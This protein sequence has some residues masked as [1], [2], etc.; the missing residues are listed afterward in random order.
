[1]G[2][3]VVHFLFGFYRWLW[4]LSGIGKRKYVT[5]TSV[6]RPSTTA[7]SGRTP[8]A[9]CFKLP[10]ANSPILTAPGTPSETWEP[11]PGIAGQTCNCAID[12]Q[13]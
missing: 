2:S 12:S 4:S 7:S 9:V 10:L 8:A 13:L 11:A 5:L 1:M 3:L 6:A